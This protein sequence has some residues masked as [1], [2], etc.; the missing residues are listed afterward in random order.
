MEKEGSAL[1]DRPPMI[2]ADEL[3]SGGKR[4]S[5]MGSGERFRRLRK[6][7]HSHFQVKAL[8]MYNDT[9]FD[10]ARTLILD[11]LD[12]PKNHQKHAHRYVSVH[13]M[14]GFCV[15]L[16]YVAPDIPHL[17]SYVLHMASRAP[18]LSMIRTSLT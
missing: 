15:A 12:D 9:Q 4:I 2:A 13:S 8:E 3:L 5:L 16:A 1:A 10:Q 14:C 17:S 18:R 6:A 7:I 11:I